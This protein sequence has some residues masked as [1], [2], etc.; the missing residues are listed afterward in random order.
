MKSFPLLWTAFLILRWFLFLKQS[1]FMLP[2]NPNK[3][4]QKHHANH[5][6]HKTGSQKAYKR[7]CRRFQGSSPKPVE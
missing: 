6:L 7:A 3:Q 2:N 5:E 4:S 1:R